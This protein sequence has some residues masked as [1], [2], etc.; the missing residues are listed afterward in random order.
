MKCVVC[1]KTVYDKFTNGLCSSCI[2]D[3]KT[4]VL[5]GEK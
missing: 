1:A 5:G 4:R 3:W 2:T